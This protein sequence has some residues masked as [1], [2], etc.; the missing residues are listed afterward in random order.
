[1][2]RIWRI[3]ATSYFKEFKGCT[4]FILFFVRRIWIIRDR[5][6]ENDTVRKISTCIYD[7]N[8]SLWKE[9]EESMQQAKTHRN[10]IT[11]VHDVNFSSW[12]EYEDSTQQAISK[13]S[14]A[15]HDSSCSSWEEYGEYITES[16]KTTPSKRYQLVYM[17]STVLR[18]KNIKNLYNKL[19]D[20]N[21]ITCVH[22]VNCSLWKEYEESMQ[23]AIKIYSISIKKIN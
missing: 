23:Q 5:I 17:M 8:C 12:K 19:I 18:E 2:K 1:M 10:K 21:K 3:N 14:R 20:Q 7:V 15:V 11:C 22:D 4:Q 9:Y 16:M 13:N 6:N